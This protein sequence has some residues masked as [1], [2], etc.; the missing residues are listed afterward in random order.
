M[1]NVNGKRDIDSFLETK[2][3]PRK[4]DQQKETS[5]LE[6]LDSRQ[7]DWTF[8]EDTDDDHDVSITIKQEQDN[9][10]N[11]ANEKKKPTRDNVYDYDPCVI[12]QLEKECGPEATYRKYLILAHVVKHLRVKDKREL[13][14]LMRMQ[15][16]DNEHVFFPK[17]G[18][19]AGEFAIFR[20]VFFSSL[21]SLFPSLFPSLFLFLSPSTIR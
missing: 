11:A 6:N 13:F 21:L 16:Q 15:G 18:M 17:Y 1:H 8:V 12:P 10:D 9:D 7:V 14:K 20:M 4:E 2:K 3:R 5:N 19:T